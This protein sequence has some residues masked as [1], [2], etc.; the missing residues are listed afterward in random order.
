VRNREKGVTFIEIMVVL[1]IGSVLTFAIVTLLRNTGK[2]VASTTGKAEFTNLVNELQ[3][4][5]NNAGRCQA[6][7]A[8]SRSYTPPPPPPP[9]VPPPTVQLVPDLSPL[10][11]TG[12]ADTTPIPISLV[13]GNTDPAKGQ[14]SPPVGAGTQ[15]GPLTIKKLELLGKKPARDAP[16]ATGGQSHWQL[17]MLLEASRRAGEGKAGS[18]TAIGGDLLRKTF[19]LTVTLGAN[20]NE[21]VGCMGQSGGYWESV[22]PENLHIIYRKG[23]VGIGMD[24]GTDIKLDIDGQA[25]GMTYSYRSDGRLKANVREIPGVLGRVLQ[26][27]GVL[28][29]WKDPSGG[30]NQLGFLAQEVEKVFPEAVL[31]NKQTGLK[32]VDYEKLIPPVIEAVKEQQ[33]ILKEQAR[34]LAMLREAARAAR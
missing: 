13:L 10:G 11:E 5:F 32:S 16:V 28:F 33:R 14:V 6:I 27:H 34:D 19:N 23:S 22:P 15:W 24:P 31:T 17:T 30:T 20:K 9:A 21:V 26:L 8:A 1:G 29:D 25:Q 18:E 3:A 2:E 4:N 12:A 7:F